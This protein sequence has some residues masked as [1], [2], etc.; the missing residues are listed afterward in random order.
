MGSER[1]FA[2]VELSTLP[3]SFEDDLAAYATAGVHGIGIFEAKL[4]PGREEEGLAAFRESGLKAS[5]AIPAV[6]SILPLPRL[7][8]PD[9][10]EERIEAYTAGMRR[11]ARFEPTAFVCLTGP[12]GTLPDEQARATIVDGLRAL[13]AEASRLG[14]PVGLE[15]MS[16][17]YPGWTVVTTLGEAGELIANAGSNGLGLTFDTWHLWDTPTLEE[18]LARHG[19]QIVAV[20]VSDWREPTRSWCDRVL[21]GVGV[22]D[23]DRMLGALEAAGWEGFYELEIFS[24]DGT[25]GDAFEDSL[26]RIPAAEL[27][28]RGRRAFEAVGVVYPSKVR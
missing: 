24:D 18:D 7:P 3:A 16:V 4:V 5:A 27:A 12:A 19:E 10:A 11:L 22:I 25:F 6:P 13:G 20:H 8:G 9:T 14:I 23:F 21:P 17:D 1:P 15:P 28:E 2:I 26:W